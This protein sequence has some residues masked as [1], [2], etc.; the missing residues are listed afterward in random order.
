MKKLRLKNYE[1][2][3]KKK[4]KKITLKYLFLKALEN[5]SPRLW[6][7]PWSGGGAFGRA[8]KASNPKGGR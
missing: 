7:Q 5:L 1:M 2:K 3:K 8:S 6:S 4:K